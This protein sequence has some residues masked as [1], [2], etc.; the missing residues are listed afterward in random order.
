MSDP[1]RLDA[2]ELAVARLTKEL[3]SLRSEV[4]RLNASGGAAPNAVPSTPPE[5]RGVAWRGAR[6]ELSL[7][8]PSPT[9]ELPD[10]LV[11]DGGALVT[12]GGVGGPPLTTSLPHDPTT[13]TSLPRTPNHSIPTASERR[14]PYVSDELRRLARAT[15][16]GDEAGRSSA[17]G[18]ASAP[19]HVP[20]PLRNRQNLEALVGRYGTLALAALTILMGVGAFLNWAIRNGVIGPELRVAL[21]AVAAL[22][23]GALGIRL[24]K[25]DSPRFGSVLLALALAIVH[26]VCWGAGPL[27]HLVP[28]VVALGLALAASA[29]LAIL[30]LR[31]EDQSLFNV[32][33][34]GALLAPFVTASGRGDAVLLLLYGALVIAAGMR[35]MRDREWSKTPLVLA[36][37]V[38][39]YTVTSTDQLMRSESWP[40]ATAPAIFSLAVSW[41]S[42][43]LVRGKPRERVA[44]VAL[45]ALFGALAALHNEPSIIWPRYVLAALLTLTGFLVGTGERNRGLRAVTGGLLFPFAGLC[46]VLL[47]LDDATTAAGAIATSLWAVASVGA[48]YFNRDGERHTHAFTA[49]AFGGLALALPLGETRVPYVVATAGYG[50]AVTVLMRRFRLT[51]VGIAVFAWLVVGALVAFYELAHRT[52]FTYP[53]FL[54]SASAAAAAISGAWLFFSWH[55][56]RTALPAPTQSFDLPRGALRILGGVVAFLWVHEELA[57]AVSNDVATFLLVAYYATSGIVAI[58]IGRWR[59]IAVLRQLGLALAV[60][61][62]FKI[63]LES[64]GLTIGWRVAGF[65]LAGLFLLGVAYWYRA[66]GAPRATS[67]P[68][69]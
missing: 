18:P 24:R 58:G 13:P 40:R 53:P 32:G 11:T 65:M 16:S 26:V 34:G 54:T 4:G 12:D 43:I 46:I 27:L 50:A 62:A 9:P 68:E 1:S 42:L 19:R 30:A 23:M 38:A 57:H 47:N 45:L 10:S 48:A 56:A 59:E 49:T 64:S 2:I 22:V 31:E 20:A 36:I 41:L 5:P 44:N 51:G 69:A 7:Q 39:W 29:G 14:E 17:A 52:P 25:G 37:G 67:L 8:S 21:G 15:G 28:D 35:A 6:V 66:A 60:F 3:V 61:A 33:F 55:A 63:M